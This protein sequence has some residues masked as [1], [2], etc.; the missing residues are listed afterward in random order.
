VGFGRALDSGVPGRVEL[1][2]EE[3]FDGLREKGLDFGEPVGLGGLFAVLGPGLAEFGFVAGVK[4]ELVLVDGDPHAG[5]L[6]DL[7]VEHKADHV[8][9]HLLLEL[10]LDL[11]GVADERV[12]VLLELGEQALVLGVDSG[13]QDDGVEVDLAGSG[14][15]VEHEFGEVL[16]EA[17]L[18]EPLE[19]EGAGGEFLV[20]V[21][22]EG[23]VVAEGDQ[24]TLVDVVDEFFVIEFENFGEGVEG[25]G[26]LVGFDCVEGECVEV[27]DLGH[28]VVVLV[29]VGQQLEDAHHQVEQLEH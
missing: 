5:H 16:E 29:A 21:A 4:L 17:L 19:F 28:D 2:L 7:L 9:G 12:D 26:V 10:H 13:E 15:L 20:G 22:E 25:V 8:L 27:V 18:E 11:E 14:G 24:E 3:H 23:E 1:L 6:L